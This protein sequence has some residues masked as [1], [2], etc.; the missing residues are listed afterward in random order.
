M[1]RVGAATSL[2]GAALGTRLAPR[3]DF[4]TKG[5][6]TSGCVT[7]T[8]SSSSE[9]LA[10]VLGVEVDGGCG[11]VAGS[12]VATTVAEGVAVADGAGVDST[13]LASAVGAVETW[14]VAG[15]LVMRWA[16]WNFAYPTYPAMARATIT[17]AT[18]IPFL[19]PAL[20][21]ASSDKSR[22]A[23]VGA[24]LA[25]ASV[26]ASEAVGRMV[27][28][29][30]GAAVGFAEGAVVAHACSASKVVVGIC[31]FGVCLAGAGALAAPRNVI[32]EDANADRVSFIGG[33]IW[34][35]RSPKVGTDSFL[36]AG[37]DAFDRGL[38]TL[39][40]GLETGCHGYFCEL[41]G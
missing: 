15:L 13:V 7:V 38:P 10:L 40:V 17:A 2:A 32:T 19:L 8:S 35:E 1:P 31:G 23:N 27:G 36:P 12:G 3:P 9:E 18:K 26:S 16:T 20:V 4:T 28:L 34:M 30:A 5:G 33:A 37:V 25:G 6:A 41:V 14:P 24:D 11:F 39:P 29:A 22:A 21:E